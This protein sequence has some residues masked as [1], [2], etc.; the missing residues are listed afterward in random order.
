[1]KA[2]QIEAIRRRAEAATAGPWTYIETTD[3]IYEMPKL[4]GAE[5]TVMSFGDCT[6]Y[7]PIEGTPPGDADAD[8]IANAR[9]DIP[10]LLAEIER[11]HESH[12]VIYDRLRKTTDDIDVSNECR[13]IVKEMIRNGYVTA[14]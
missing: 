3:D 6:T 7:Y 2:E 10:A 11:L 5:F 9:E 13:R 14:R 8:F 12:R 1:M 4:E